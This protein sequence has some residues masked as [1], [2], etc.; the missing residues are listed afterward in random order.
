[1]SAET[2]TFLVLPINDIVLYYNVGLLSA[3]DSEHARI[4]KTLNG[5]QTRACSLERTI[6]VSVET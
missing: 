6:Y 1:V 4:C 5:L 2:L 3:D